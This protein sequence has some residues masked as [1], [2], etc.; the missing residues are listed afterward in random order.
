VV[1]LISDLL[2]L[3]V[4]G[5][6]ITDSF[7]LMTP[8]PQSNISPSMITAS[9]LPNLMTMFHDFR[10]KSSSNAWRSALTQGFESEGYEKR[11]CDTCGSAMSTICVGGGDG[12]RERV[13]RS[14]ASGKRQD[15]KDEK[16]WDVSYGSFVERRS[17]HLAHLQ[18]SARFREG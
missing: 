18:L 14:A 8:L 16:N 12:P 1:I 17:A 2:M 10:M 13:C 7:S 11:G 5:N 15:D 9:T 6:R 4:R 3:H